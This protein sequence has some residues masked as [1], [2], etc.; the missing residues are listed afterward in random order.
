MIIN[1]NNI[2][3]IFSDCPTRKYKQRKTNRL[4]QIKPTIWEDCGRGYHI[5]RSH[6]G[7]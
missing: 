1:N 2:K 7:M 6:R 5:Q 4:G 3:L